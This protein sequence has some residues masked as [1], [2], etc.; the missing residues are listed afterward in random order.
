MARM[1]G[2]NVLQHIVISC[3]FISTYSYS[4]LHVTN[5]QIWQRIIN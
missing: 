1:K 4:H 3:W 2:T 5:S